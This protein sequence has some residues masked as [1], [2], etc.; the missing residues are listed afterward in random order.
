M[1]RDGRRPRRRHPAWALPV[2]ATGG[3]EEGVADGREVW[4][5]AE[6]WSPPMSPR[7]TFL[8]GNE[9]IYVEYQIDLRVLKIKMHLPWAKNFLRTDSLAKSYSLSKE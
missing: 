5:A 8:F 9:Y 3:G 6:I 2:E 1:P 7:L 4:L